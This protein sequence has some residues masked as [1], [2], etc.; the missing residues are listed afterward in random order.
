[1]GHQLLALYQAWLVAAAMSRLS[2]E[3]PQ[4]SW[5]IA[6]IGLGCVELTETLSPPSAV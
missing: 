2:V 1:M 6:T 3:L 5:L 4:K